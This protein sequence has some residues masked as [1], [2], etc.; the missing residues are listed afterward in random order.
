[1]SN[2]NKDWIYDEIQ[3]RCLERGLVD[4]ITAVYPLP[5][6]GLPQYVEGLRNGQKVKYYVHLTEEGWLCE[7]RE[8]DHFD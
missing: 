7:H 5:H 3:E 1:M 6:E 8:L 2:M 4:K